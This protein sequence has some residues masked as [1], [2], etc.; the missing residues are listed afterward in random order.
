MRSPVS[1]PDSRCAASSVIR[2]PA[3][4]LLCDAQKTACIGRGWERSG[5]YDRK[6]RRVRDLSC[7]DTRVFLEFE[8]RRV[9]C[10]RCRTVKREQLDFLAD[11]PL[12]TRRFA[13]YVGRR[14]R[15][16]SIKGVAKELR[17]D[18]HTVK[19]LE[20]QYMTAQLAKA[21]TPGPKAIGIDEISIRKG[22]AYRIVVSDL[23]RGRPIWFGGTNRPEASMR[24]FYD[25]L[26][27]N[28]A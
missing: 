4:S 7:G 18:W 13:F 3:S 21:G 27:G 10:R 5:W 25:W 22:H 14:C 6:H 20:K 9:F 17:L 15:S 24:Q 28:K 1:D 23:I 12:Y 2:R 11:N 16:A 26:R 19:Q 8:V